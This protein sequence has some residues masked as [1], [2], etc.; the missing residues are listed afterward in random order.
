MTKWHEADE[1]WETMAPV[2]F[3]P[4][5][6][7][8]APEEAARAVRLA[9][10]KSP[11]PVLDL[12]CGPGRHSAEWA[13]LGFDVTG[14]D[15]TEAY[16]EE[17]RRHSA[18]L[19]ATFVRDDMRQ[20]CRPETYEAVFN[21]YNSFGYF[22]DPADDRRVL[23]NIRESLV[24]GGRVVIEVIGKEFVARELRERSWMEWDGGFLLESCR[25]R[26]NWSW[27]E[28]RWILIHSGGIDE[29]TWGHRLYAASE[30]VALLTD[31]GFVGPEIYGDLDGRTYDRAAVRLV[32]VA[33]KAQTAS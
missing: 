12:C 9:G 24:P 11:A 7:Q 15:R 5:R 13:R 25:I 31:C 20:F 10:V 14:V 32:A 27:L 4:G 29:C 18:G 21:L 8:A 6:R 30:F 22:E 2:M 23:E 1:F 17:A 26:N 33:R 28:N 16:L 19:K 3:T